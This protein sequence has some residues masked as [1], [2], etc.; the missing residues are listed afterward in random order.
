MRAHRLTYLRIPAALALALIGLSLAGQVREAPARDAAREQMQRERERARNLGQGV[1]DKTLR[2][3]EDEFNLGPHKSAEERLDAYLKSLRPTTAIGPIPLKNRLDHYDPATSGAIR[4]LRESMGSYDFSTKQWQKDQKK[5][6]L[7]DLPPGEAESLGK[8]DWLKY[9]ETN[10]PAGKEALGNPWPRTNVARAGLAAHLMTHTGSAAIRHIVWKRGD[11]GANGVSYQAWEVDEKTGVAGRFLSRAE[12]DS[13]YGSGATVVNSGD[14]PHG[15]SWRAYAASHPGKAVIHEK[16]SA[17]AD[18]KAIREATAL[19]EK[20][21]DPASTKVFNALPQ[22]TDEEASRLERARMGG[23]VGTRE[24]WQAV[25]QR[26]RES[27]EG[28]HSQVADKQSLMDELQ[29]GRASVV[30]IYAHFDGV[31]LYMP[32]VNG[33]T[34]SVD[35]IRRINRTGDSTVGHRTIVLAAC[36]TAAAPGGNGAQSLVQVLL[37]NGVARNV[38]ATDRPYDARDIPALLTSLRLKP[39]QEASDRLSPHVEIEWPHELRELYLKDSPRGEVTFS[40]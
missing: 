26:I 30:V 25:N 18:W 15:P 8:V 23:I 20:T 31:R 1:D 21:L 6:P 3:V 40:E 9:L 2:E 34:I 12:L 19:A 5:K 10:D 38:F 16:N 22:E 36:S 24:A 4:Q 14:V 11:N 35:E 27:A 13:M 7:V 33:E 28:F 17:N 32:G 29:H 39:M 37:E